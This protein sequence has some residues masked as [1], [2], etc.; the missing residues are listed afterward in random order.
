MNFE[1]H[2]L[3]NNKRVS[4][5]RAACVSVSRSVINH[6]NRVVALLINLLLVLVIILLILCTGMRLL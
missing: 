6:N 1:A 5:R 3:M 2:N 4:A